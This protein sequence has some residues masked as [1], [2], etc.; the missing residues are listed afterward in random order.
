[1]ARIRSFNLDRWSEPDEQR[2]V[3]HIGMADARET[4][5]K[6]KKHLEATGLLP[7]EYFLFDGAYETQL[8]GELPN[9]DHALCVP[10]YGASEGIYLDI[11]LVCRNEDGSRKFI[12]FATGKTLE[13]S[14]DAFLRMHRIAGECS[15][16]LNGRGI[17]FERSETPLFLTS[18]ETDAVINALELEILSDISPE[19]A[20]LLEGVMGKIDGQRLTPVCAVACHGVDDYSLWTADLP[21]AVV[22]EIARDG[23]KVHGR[24]E[25]LMA[26]MAPDTLRIL[27]P[28]QEEGEISFSTIPE[29][30]DNL[31]AY[32]NWGGSERG[33]K[34][35]ILSELQ[36]EMGLEQS[37]GVEQQMGGMQI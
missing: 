28:Y 33:S 18:E 10:N 3:W 2:R 5:E 31:D 37:E 22:Q 11:S 16:L 29:R 17:Y 36:K 13:E 1:M 8:K 25:D 20:R 9:F 23:S 26:Q 27:F 12:P 32:T 34:E 24:P 19:Q 14:G 15:L 35:D 4:F 21:V 30:L 6:L 7:D